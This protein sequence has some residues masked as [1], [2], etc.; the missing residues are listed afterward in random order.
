MC[1]L[2]RNKKGDIIKNYVLEGLS[3][4][5]FVSCL[6]EHSISLAVISVI[7]TGSHP[8]TL[9]TLSISACCAL[10]TNIMSHQHIPMNRVA[11]MAEFQHKSV[12][13]IQVLNH[14]KAILVLNFMDSSYKISISLASVNVESMIVFSSKNQ[15]DSITC[16]RCPLATSSWDGCVYFHRFD[17]LSGGLCGLRSYSRKNNYAVLSVQYD[18]NG[19]HEFSGGHDNTIK[20]GEIN[21]NNGNNNERAAVTHRAL[22]DND[23]YNQLCLFLE[24]YSAH[25]WQY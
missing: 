8:H 1:L 5:K 16:I 6:G 18:N 10:T 19:D 11:H 22:Q 21:A 2:K 20:C 24:D 7:F 17:L 23:K 15:S 9:F 25:K 14:S 13:S 4:F 12:L 3:G